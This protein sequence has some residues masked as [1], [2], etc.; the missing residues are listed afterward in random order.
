MPCYH[1]T[2]AWRTATNKLVFGAKSRPTW[3]Y[4]PI[5]C[6]HCAGCRTTKAQGWT[7]RAILEQQ[8]HL[9]S[10]FTTLTVD[11]ARNTGSLDKEAYK[12]FIKRLRER[13]RSTTATTIRHF[14]CGEYGEQ[15]QRPHYHAIIFG[16]GHEHADTIEK[17]WGHGLTQTVQANRKTIAYTAGYVAK[18]LE[19]PY[20]DRDDREPP[21]LQM[22]R[23]PGIG[24][25]ARK[26]WKMWKEYAVDNGTKMPVPRYLHEEW[27]NQATFKENDA[28]Q[29]ARAEYFKLAEP[30][31]LKAAELI[32]EAKHQLH[33][34]IKL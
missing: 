2:T 33:R 34:R 27:K 26:H 29:E 16:L 12:G 32:A 25:H 1:P 5:P 20:M 23:K 17:A 13:L 15:T 18:K 21:F 3:T 10:V 28:L 22:S 8:Q 31:D 11:D 19:S 9:H 4:A 24:A 30:I 14:G 7:L 6:N